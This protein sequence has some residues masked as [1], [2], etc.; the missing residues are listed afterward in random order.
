[1][2]NFRA[3]KNAVC[4]LENAFDVDLPKIDLSCGNTALQ[5]ACF[6]PLGL[7]YVASALMRAGYE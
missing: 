1:M 4:D 5:C 6:H 7:A 3:G 2:D